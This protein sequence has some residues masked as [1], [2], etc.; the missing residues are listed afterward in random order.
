MLTKVINIQIFRNHMNGQEWSSLMFMLQWDPPFSYNFSTI[1]EE[2]WLD[3]FPTFS[4]GSWNAENYFL[5]LES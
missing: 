3:A 1:N 4:P 5:V 2:V